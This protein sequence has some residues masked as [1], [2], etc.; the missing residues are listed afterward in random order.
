ME[1]FLLTNNVLRVVPNVRNE[2]GAKNGFV[3]FSFETL[4]S[5]EMKAN[6]LFPGM[7][8]HANTDWT[9]CGTSYVFF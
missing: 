6:N 1:H 7:V 2:E 5:E 8:C 3:D 9:P 4:V